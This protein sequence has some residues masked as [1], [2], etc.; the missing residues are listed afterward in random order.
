[1]FPYWLMFAILA[2]GAM[3]APARPMLKRRAAFWLVMALIALFVGLRFEVGPDWAGY[4]NI[5]GWSGRLTFAEVLEGGDVGFF[6]I[7]W[8]LHSLDAEFWALNLVCAI[9]FM[10]GLSSFA[11]RMPNPWLAVAIAF[12]YLI[13]VLAMSGVRQATAIGFFFFALGAFSD[14]RF[15][16]ATLFLLV[17][18]SFHASAIVMMGVAAMAMT[19]NRLAGLAVLLL[20][21]VTGIFVLDADFERYINRYTKESVQSGGVLFR[22]AMNLLPALIYL[23]WNKRFDL[24]SHERALWRI[25]AWLSVACVPA[26]FLIESTTVLDRF[27]LY[28]SPIQ[29]FVLGWL[30]YLAVRDTKGAGLTVGVLLA[31]LFTVMF[32]FLNFSTH[33][34]A[35][36]PYQ[37]YLFSDTPQEAREPKYR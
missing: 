27:S 18:A 35:W 15:V 17:A 9:I 10:A 1:M 2:G 3:L 7:I 30:P 33:G 21:A 29:V 6:S 28:L 36:D 14:R 13:V 25:I 19:H 20:T 5:W 23:A 11:V 24:Q 4:T 22:I 31:Y 26:F 16:K 37:S 34:Y 8:V 32:V 12:P